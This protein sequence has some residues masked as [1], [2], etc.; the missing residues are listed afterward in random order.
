MRK[1]SNIDVFLCVSFMV[2]IILELSNN[3]GR[4]SEVMDQNS[5]LEELN[6]RSKYINR[7]LIKIL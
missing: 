6:K 1:K 4:L 2:I 3:S 7:N 5:F